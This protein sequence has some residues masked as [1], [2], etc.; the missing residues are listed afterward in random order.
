MLSTKSHQYR[1]LNHRP[2]ELPQHTCHPQQQRKYQNS[3]DYDLQHPEPS[4]GP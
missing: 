1:N 2:Y 3:A 4:Q